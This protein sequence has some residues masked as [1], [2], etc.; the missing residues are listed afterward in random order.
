MPLLLAQKGNW[1]EA[2]LLRCN[3]PRKGSPHFDLPQID[4]VKRKF[5]KKF[6]NSILGTVL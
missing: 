3:Y 6:S 1:E 2:G 5:G 4:V